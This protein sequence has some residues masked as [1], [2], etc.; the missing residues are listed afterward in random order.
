MAQE[1]LRVLHLVPK[2]N[3]RLAS[4]KLGEGP[5]NPPHSDTLP[6]KGH[7]YSNK[8]ISPNS[9]IPWAKHIETTT[10]GNK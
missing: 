10:L 8:A 3:R 1:E 9:A 6:P 4:T 5:Q 2:A 7:A